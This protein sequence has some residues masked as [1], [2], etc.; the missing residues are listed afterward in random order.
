MTSGLYA[1]MQVD[2]LYVLADVVR[3][4]TYGLKSPRIVAGVSARS[5][6]DLVGRKEDGWEMWE[7]WFVAGQLIRCSLSCPS[8]RLIQL[9]PSAESK[10][11]T[12][13]AMFEL[14]YQV[15]YSH[16][17]SKIDAGQ[18]WPMLC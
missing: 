15:G 5:G 13:W 4:R 1:I 9:D 3:L 16:A 2:Y 14:D 18:H 6:T 17:I 8:L 12:N 7:N 11:K 10:A